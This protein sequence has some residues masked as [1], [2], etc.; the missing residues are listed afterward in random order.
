MSAHLD[1][2]VVGS[3]FGGAVMAYRLRET[4]LDVCFLERGRP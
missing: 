1:A 3:G 4:S 2:I